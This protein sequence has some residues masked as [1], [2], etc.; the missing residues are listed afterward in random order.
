MLFLGTNMALI[1]VFTAPFFT[2]WV[3]KNFGSE[4]GIFNPY[5]VR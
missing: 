4:G 2:T 3:E 1:Y 5:L